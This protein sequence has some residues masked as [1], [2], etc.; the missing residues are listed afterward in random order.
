MLMF[1]IT[2]SKSAARRLQKMQPKKA[3]SILA[4]V[5]RIAARPEGKHVNVKPLSNVEDGYRLRS[6][7]WRVSYV[8]D[9]EAETLDVF[10]I[11]PRGGAYR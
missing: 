4:T 9:R 11:A 2:Y 5:E 8:I 1:T 7:D 6:G 3:A 10:A